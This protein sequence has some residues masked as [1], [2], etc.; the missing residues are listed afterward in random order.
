MIVIERINSLPIDRLS[1]LVTEANATGF[2]AL[3]RLLTEW[4]SGLNQF[5]SQGKPS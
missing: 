1:A 2:H 3:S 5:T 4:R